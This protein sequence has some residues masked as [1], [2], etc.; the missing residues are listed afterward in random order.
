[1][2]SLKLVFPIHGMGKGIEDFKNEFYAAGEGCIA[3]GGGGLD[4]YENISEYIDHCS[5]MLTYSDDFL[6]PSSQYFGVVDKRIVGCIQIRHKLNDHLSVRGGHIGYSVRPTE[7]RKGYASQ[8]LASALDLCPALGITNAL[9]TCDIANKASARTILKNGGILE[10]EL[11]ESDGD[12]VHRFWIDTATRIRRLEKHEL[13]DALD[14]IHKSF[15]TVAEEFGLTRENCPRHTSF[16]P[17]QFL[18]T[19]LNWGWHMFALFEGERIV[20]YVSMSDEGGGVFE[21]HNLS[22]LPEK[23]HRGYGKALLSYCKSVAYFKGAEKV[24][25]GLIDESNILKEWYRK[26]GFVHTGTKKFE[27]LPFTSGYMEWEVSVEKVT[28]A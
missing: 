13:T 7:R 1:M 8:M 2:K 16:M 27:H 25:L 17:I 20:G 14:V 22:V 18:E 23:R 10:N 3:G 21:L 5:S 19:Q 12:R 6:V 26:N 28:E 24:R 11:T 15:A 4:S 9:I